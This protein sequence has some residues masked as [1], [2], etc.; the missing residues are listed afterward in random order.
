[1]E[2]ISASYTMEYV[3]LG[4]EVCDDAAL[5]AEFDALAA[6]EA[7]KENRPP[8][9]FKI[10]SDFAPDAAPLRRSVSD[11]SKPRAALQ[12]IP[13]RGRIGKKADGKARS[14]LGGIGNMDFSAE[15]GGVGMKQTINKAKLG[16]RTEATPAVATVARPAVSFR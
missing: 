16:D 8:I 10:A 1:M 6:A 14:V 13:L 2:V 9:S 12:E 5:A 3:A 15:L 11:G 4:S 7:D